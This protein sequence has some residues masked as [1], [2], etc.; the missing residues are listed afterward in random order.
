MSLLWSIVPTELVYTNFYEQPPTLVEVQRGGVT[1][2]VSP[3][4]NGMA[5]MERLISPNPQDYLRKEWQPG[6]LIHLYEHR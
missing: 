6:T 4:Q 1:M 3:E 2:L 5:K